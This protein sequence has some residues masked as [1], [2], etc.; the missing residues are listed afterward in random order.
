MYYLIFFLALRVGFQLNQYYFYEPTRRYSQVE[1]V[2]LIKENN[3]VTEQTFGVVIT[4]G[5][6]G[7]GTIAATLMPATGDDTFDYVVGDPGDYTLLLDFL[8]EE[9]KRTF[10][11]AVYADDLDEG[12]EGFRASLSPQ[13]VP[14]PNFALQP[15]TDR[16]P[17]PEAVIKIIDT[18]CKF[19]IIECVLC[20]NFLSF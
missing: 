5:D 12:T 20:D 1:N 8:P 14:F 2:T 13:G 17:Y 6:P 4:F 7:I 15:T 11:F 9:S 16:S 10:S 19:R 18:D 3:G